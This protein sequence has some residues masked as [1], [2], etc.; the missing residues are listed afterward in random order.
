MY[1]AGSSVF[2]STGVSN[3]TMTIIALSIRLAEYLQTK[4]GK[5]RAS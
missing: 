1:V 2:P 5:T 4:V 3:P